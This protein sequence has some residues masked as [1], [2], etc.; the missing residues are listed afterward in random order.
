MKTQVIAAAATL[1]LAASGAALAGD[2]YKWVDAEG[3]VHYGDRPAGAQSE[4]MAI[5]SKP[6]DEARVAAQT[7][8]RADARQHEGSGA[9]RSFPKEYRTTE[10]SS[11]QQCV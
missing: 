8:A 10:Q 2:I 7:Q 3:N 1:A 6:T 11:A 5:D 4:R 9:F